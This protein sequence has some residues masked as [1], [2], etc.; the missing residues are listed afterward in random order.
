MA[1]LPQRPPKKSSS[2]KQHEPSTRSGHTRLIIIFGAILSAYEIVSSFKDFSDSIQLIR[3]EADKLIQV[4]V[5]RFGSFDTRVSVRYPKI[6]DDRDMM[7]RMK[8]DIE[9]Q[10]AWREVYRSRYDGF[11]YFLLCLCIIQFIIIALLVYGAVMRT[12]F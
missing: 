6:D 4:A 2:A 8:M 7:R 9:F 12:Y 3:E 10:S 1:L 11:F 5:R